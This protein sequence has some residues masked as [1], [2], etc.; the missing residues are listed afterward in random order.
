MDLPVNAATGWM[1]KVQGNVVYIE[2]LTLPVEGM[3]AVRCG[4]EYH[5]EFQ[6]SLHRVCPCD[7]D[8]VSE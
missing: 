1:R 7:E 2:S 6:A 8:M 3:C 4:G 5:A